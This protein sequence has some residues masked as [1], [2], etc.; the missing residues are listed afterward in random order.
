MKNNYYLHLI[1]LCICF[2]AFS[3][4]LSAQDKTY[5]SGNALKSITESVFSHLDINYID[6]IITS[7]G[8]TFNNPNYSEPGFIFPKGTGN[9]GIY[10]NSLWIGGMTTNSQV[11]FSGE[12]YYGTDFSSGPYANNFQ[13]D[14]ALRWDKTWKISRKEIQDHCLHYSSP[15][16]IMPDVIREWPANGDV[17]IGQRAILAPFIDMDADGI[18]APEKGD[19]PNIRGDQA[20]FFIYNDAALPHRFSNYQKLGVEIQGMAYAFDCT[21]EE[22]FANSVFIHYDI[23]NRST[24]TYTNTYLGLETDFSTDIDDF[25]YIQCDVERNAVL[26]YPLIPQDSNIST[27]PSNT[28]VQSMV[29]LSGPSMDKDLLDNPM[30]DEYGDI[31]CGYGVNGMNFGDGIIDNEHYGL[32]TFTTVFQYDPW[33]LG[34]HEPYYLSMVHPLNH[35]FSQVRYGGTTDGP[36][37]QFMFPGNSDLQNWGTGCIAP[38]G[39]KEWTFESAGLD[40][41]SATRTL[42][43]MGPFTF[44]PGDRQELDVVYTATSSVN[45]NIYHTVNLAKRNASLARVYFEMNETACGGNITSTPKEQ[46]SSQLKVFPNPAEGIIRLSFPR[47]SDQPGYRL[48]DATGRV[49]KSGNL[50]SDQTLTIEE[51]S[52][53]YY[54]V[55]VKSGVKFLKAG[56]IKK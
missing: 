2:A 29:M 16:Y 23:F 9:P 15:G 50:P 5:P 19:Y 45:G 42:S 17:S 14:Y 56:F 26:I 54:L 3:S 13:S 52:P 37:C 36:P 31:L 49:V 11:V 44:R 46:I 25:D 22:I 30:K 32:T 41:S 48:T 8:A 27:L 38:N 21:A 34:A 35:D 12:R 20:V 55:E 18:Y 4:S 7:R 6:A 53:G 10:S 51:L 1:L 43:S 33:G 47:L 28:V 39:P 40:P 24:E